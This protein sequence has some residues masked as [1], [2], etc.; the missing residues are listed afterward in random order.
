MANQK[1]TDLNRLNSLESDDLF[2]VVDTNSKSNSSSPTGETKGISAGSLALELN[3]IANGEV[4]IDFK[5]LRDVP[6]E[7]DEYKGGFIRINNEGTAIEF[8]DSPGASEQVFPGSVLETH[9]DGEEQ[10]YNVGDILYVSRDRMFAKANCM[11]SEKSEAVGIIRKIKINDN[12]KI[13]KINLVFNGHI[14]WDADTEV[15]GGPLSIEKRPIDANEILPTKIYNDQFLEPGK[16]YFLGTSGNLIDFDPSELINIDTSVSKPM[17]V[18]DSKTSG[19][20]MN[21]RGL[22]CTSD[23]QSSKFVI[24]EPSACN[25]IKTGDILRVKRQSVRTSVDNF[26]IQSTYDEDQISENVLPTFLGR[27]SGTTEYALCNSASQQKTTSTTEN[28]DPPVED[29]NYGCDMIGIVISSTSDFF[30][31]QTSGMVEFELPKYQTSETVT[32]PNNEVQFVDK[33]I[34]DGLF[35]PGYTY[36]VESFPINSDQLAS[37][38][39]TTELRNSVYDYS[40]DELSEYYYNVPNTNQIS[41]LGRKLEPILNGTSP[42]RNSTIIDPFTRD[43]TSGKVLSYSKPAFYAVSPTK[44]LILNQPAYPNP[45]DRCNAIDPT[46]WTPC[47]YEQ[48][49]TQNHTINRSREFTGQTELEKFSSDF[50]KTAW[51]NAGSNDLSV[52]TFIFEYTLSGESITRFE[53][54]EFVRLDSVDGSNWVYVRKIS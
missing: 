45:K 52:I 9:V 16:T 7:Y 18:A 43:H 5:N 27:E 31:I 29:D 30:E 20:L 41:V 40:P 44:I 2:I 39:Q 3:K 10:Q 42:F 1:I 13:D 19:I 50:L 37:T 46:T 25:S 33:E 49:M 32:L 8:T 17:L 36:Y 34:P 28:Q 4:G 6:N 54:H 23:E 12:N 26:L 15:F 24:Y 21:Y 14:S 35:K 11:S 47:A 53:S 51:P 48:R 38:N 22:I